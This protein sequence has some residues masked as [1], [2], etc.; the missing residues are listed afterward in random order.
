MAKRLHS[1]SESS[2][3]APPSWETPASP[4]RG[5][6]ANGDTSVAPLPPKHVRLDPQTREQPPSISCFLPPSCSGRPFASHEQFESH[7]LQAH[8]NRCL[9]C[10]RNFPSLRFLELHIAETHDPLTELKR[11]RGDKTVCISIAM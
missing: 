8:T 1:D 2:L 9:E 6:E 7:Y 4:D 11:E 10:G 5:V 3:T